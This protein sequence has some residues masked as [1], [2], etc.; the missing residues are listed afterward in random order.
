LARQEVEVAEEADFGGYQNR[1]SVS[2]DV[3]QERLKLIEQEKQDQERRTYS[4]EFM[5][6]LRDANKVRP[7]TMAMLD[8]PHKKRLARFN[9]D[10]K[11]ST[12]SDFEKFNETVGEIRILL[13]KLSSSNFELILKKLLHDFDYTPSLLYELTKIIFVKSTTETHYL[14]YYVKLCIDLFKRFNDADNPEMN[15]RKLLL[16]R[17]E[18]QFN[19]MLEQEQS[20]RK[21]RRLSIEQ[22]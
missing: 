1:H 9:K 6:S 8:F 19:K 14:E 21:E 13:N 3:E 20:D 15:F 18:K 2:V 16:T 17:C 11:T 22:V 12:K 5:M 10:V 4:I 7:P